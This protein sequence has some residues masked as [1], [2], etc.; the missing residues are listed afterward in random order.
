MKDLDNTE[1]GNGHFG[2]LMTGKPKIAHVH[3]GVTLLL[4]FAFCVAYSVL[5]LA[6]E[7]HLGSVEVVQ[8]PFL[9]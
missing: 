1:V 8:S 3:G 9:C 7:P 2:H 6:I 5:P 4:L